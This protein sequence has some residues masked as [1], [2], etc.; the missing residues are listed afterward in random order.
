MLCVGLTY[1]ATLLVGLALAMFGF[2]RSMTSVVTPHIRKLLPNST[3]EQPSVSTIRP[4]I[5]SIRRRRMSRSTR[6]SPST[7]TSEVTSSPDDSVIE[8]KTFLSS[9]PPSPVTP[10]TCSDESA[11]APSSP[12]IPFMDILSKP[13]LVR[14][15]SN[16]SAKLK[17]C[18]SKASFDSLR[19]VSPPART[20]PY[21]AP[22]FFPTPASE[23]AKD[24]TSRVRNQ[25]R[26]NSSSGSTARIRRASCDSASP[27]QA[28]RSSPLAECFTDEPTSYASSPEAQAQTPSAKFSPLRRCQSGNAPSVRSWDDNSSGETS[29]LP[30]SQRFKRLFSRSSGTPS[31]VRSPVADSQ[32]ALVSEP[33]HPSKKSPIP[34]FRRRRAQSLLSEPPVVSNV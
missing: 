3:Q 21:Q 7:S 28:C 15:S 33:G 29:S 1:S 14:A 10:E 11:A 22:Y 16:A 6:P 2:F 18:F 27:T 19:K 25:R 24:Y 8:L 9:S 13:S 26:Q 4:L 34:F 23:E 31:M 12:R 20:D 30:T 17:G 32:Q 5:E